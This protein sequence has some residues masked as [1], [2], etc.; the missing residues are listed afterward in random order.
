MDHVEFQY[1]V[2]YQAEN[3]RRKVFSFF[4]AKSWEDAKN[5]AIL[6]SREMDCVFETVDYIKDRGVCTPDTSN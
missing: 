6:K 2:Q 3:P 5:I 1:R 4:I